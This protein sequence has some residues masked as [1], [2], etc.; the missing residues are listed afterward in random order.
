MP[1]KY[2]EKKKKSLYMFTQFHDFKLCLHISGSAME[3]N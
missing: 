1:K 2:P 3:I